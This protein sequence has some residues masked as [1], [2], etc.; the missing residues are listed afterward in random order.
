MQ[1][2]HIDFFRGLLAWARRSLPRAHVRF[3]PRRQTSGRSHRGALTVHR[4][5]PTAGAP[6][7]TWR[8]APAVGGARATGVCARTEGTCPGAVLLRRAPGQSLCVGRA[9][10]VPGTVLHC[11][12]LRPC[13]PGLPSGTAW[14]FVGLT[15]TPQ[16]TSSFISFVRIIH[17][18][19]FSSG[20][21]C[22]CLAVGFSPP[23]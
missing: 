20:V 17:Q 23:S 4:P 6:G 12:P 11:P 1:E 22:V 15:P 8:K 18:H 16:D 13:D 10:D 9:G 14:R 21:I 5:S 7:A 19:L 3:W 2:L